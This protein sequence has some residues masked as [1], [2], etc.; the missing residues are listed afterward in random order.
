MNLHEVY[1]AAQ[2]ASRSCMSPGSE[3]YEK[4]SVFSEDSAL[5][6]ST[7]G[8]QRKNMLLNN[9]RTVTKNGVTATVNEDGSITLNGTSTSSAVVT[10]FVNMQTGS[11]SNA[12]AN[13]KKWLPNGRYILSGAAPDSGVYIQVAFS[14]DNASESRYVSTSAGE[15]EFEVT[16]ADKYAWARLRINANA[17]FDNLTVYPMIRYA[18]IADD[19]YEPYKPSVEE[20]LAALESAAFTVKSMEVNNAET[21]EEVTI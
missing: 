5:N 9:C 3:A 10:I 20:R 1:L 11:T 16:D 2:I 12:Y 15:P 4:L 8:Y 7:L 14:E 18:E 17:A 13:N 21:Y 19:A 6:R